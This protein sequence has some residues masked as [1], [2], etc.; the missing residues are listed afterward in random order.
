MA[1]TPA[2]PVPLRTL[3][4]AAV[5][6][7]GKGRARL[8]LKGAAGNLSLEHPAFDLW[9][10]LQAAQQNNNVLTV[11]FALVPEELA[12]LEKEAKDIV[13]NPRVPKVPTQAEAASDDENPFA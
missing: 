12:R 7:T 10:A 1:I 8:T 6:R 2:P 13:R 9:E 5:S 3:A 11:T 4:F